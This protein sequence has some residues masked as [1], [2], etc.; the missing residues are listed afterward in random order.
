MMTAA[1]NAKTEEAKAEFLRLATEWLKL[2]AAISKR[3]ADL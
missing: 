2:A 3:L 1:A